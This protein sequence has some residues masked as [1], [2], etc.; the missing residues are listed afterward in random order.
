MSRGTAKTSVFSKCVKLVSTRYITHLSWLICSDTH[1]KDTAKRDSQ[2]GGAE[3]EHG[4]VGN[5]GP[6]ASSQ[7]ILSFCLLLAL[8]LAFQ[9]HVTYKG[10]GPQN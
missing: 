10:T 5:D 9:V 6:G 8:C 2:V 4:A 7:H 1:D 3:T